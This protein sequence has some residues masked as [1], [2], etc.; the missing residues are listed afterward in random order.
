MI[1][2]A[3]TKITRAVQVKRK[4]L[5][6]NPWNPNQMTQRQQEATTESLGLYG[7][8]QELLV[9][10]H[11]EIDGDYQIIDGQHRWNSLAPNDKVF[12]NIVEGLPDEQ[13]KKLTVIMNGTRGEFD[14][15]DLAQLLSELDG[16]DDLVLGLPY[17]QSELDELIGLADIDWDDF[18]SDFEEGVSNV[19]EEG[20]EGDQDD[21]DWTTLTIKVPSDV[22]PQLQEAFDLV[23]QRQEINS[24]DDTS[25]VWGE[26]V[27]HLCDHFLNF[28]L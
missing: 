16:M 17:S 8:V 18:A 10:P 11:P 9:R 1:K 21:P 19:G 23:L 15:I 5:H 6:P 14:K 7:Q 28:K 27:Q 22:M 13:C 26:V 2:K 24:S 3:D 20:E 12:V 25:I 4:Q